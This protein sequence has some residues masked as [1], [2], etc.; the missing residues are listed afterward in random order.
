MILLGLGAI[1]VVVGAT[2]LADEWRR[3][4]TQNARIN[5]EGLRAEAVAAAA[6]LLGLG[7]AIAY[8]G[9]SA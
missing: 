9:V 8:A 6:V 2:V 5:G 3:A 7:V 1:L 4:G